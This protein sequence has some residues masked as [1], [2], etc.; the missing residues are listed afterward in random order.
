MDNSICLY[1]PFCAEY[2]LK[3]LALTKDM[4][5]DCAY[6]QNPY[7]AQQFSNCPKTGE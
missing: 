2:E 1:E 3:L 4:E 5:G 6:L 7:K